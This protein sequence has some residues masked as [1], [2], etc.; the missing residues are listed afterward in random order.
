MKRMA[1]WILKYTKIFI[2]RI[3]QQSSNETVKA[4]SP[5]GLNMSL[6]KD[7]QQ[8]II[9]LPQQQ[10]FSEEIEHRRDGA[11]GGKKVLKRRIGIY[12]LDPYL[13]ENDLMRVWGRL[14]KPNQQIRDFHPVLIA[15]DYN[16][17]ILIIEW[18]YQ[19]MVEQSLP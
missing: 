1:A 3:Q 4:L 12:N 2:S 13:D 7:A 11:S 17:T 14:K 8:D 5:A 10:V 6:L 18:F 15:K 9:K 19:T 16:I